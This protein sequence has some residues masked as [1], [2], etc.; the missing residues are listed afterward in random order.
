MG[1]GKTAQAIAM[2][3]YL[4]TCESIRGPFL[5][6]A[7]LSTLAH[8]QRELEEWTEL[9]VLL[10]HGSRNSRELMLQHEFYLEAEEAG[11]AA[12]AVKAGGAPVASGVTG[13]GGTAAAEPPPPSQAQQPLHVTVAIPANVWP[14]M[15]L[16]VSHPSLLGRVFEVVVPPEMRPGMHLRVALPPRAAGG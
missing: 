1:L 14:G 11:R 7:P 10:Y 6:V 5:V 15:R 3:N 13:G 16:R 4:W 8:W 2:L 12:D 9:R